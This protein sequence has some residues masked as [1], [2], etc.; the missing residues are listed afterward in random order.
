[1]NSVSN[2]SPCFHPSKIPCTMFPDKSCWWSLC[3]GRWWQMSRPS[4]WRGGWAGWLSWEES[5]LI[6]IVG[7]TFCVKVDMI[8]TDDL[9]WPLTNYRSGQVLGLFTRS[10]SKSVGTLNII[11]T[12]LWEGTLSFRG[13]QIY[14]HNWF[15]LKKHPSMY[16]KDPRTV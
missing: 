9:Q 12:L 6:L 13:H 5:W 8:D 15:W 16:E 14:N 4:G 2:H 7:W 11:R 1:M 3:I 10:G